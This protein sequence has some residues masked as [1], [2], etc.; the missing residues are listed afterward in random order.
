[1]S[2]ATAVQFLI[3]IPRQPL[4]GQPIAPNEPSFPMILLSAIVW[5]PALTAIVLLFFPARTDAHKDR[6]RSGAL[7]ATG[8]VLGLAL[9]LWSSFRSQFQTYA[10]EENRDWIKTIGASYHLGVDGVSMALVLL[11]AILFFV[12]V[13]ASWGVRDRSKEYFILL[14]LVETGVNGV[15]ASLDFLLFF[16]F[17]EM[18]LIPMFFLIGLWGGPR[19][20]YAAWKYVAF[21]LTGSAGLLLAI[22]IMYFQAPARTFDMATLHNAKLPSA[23]GTLLFWLFFLVFASKLGAVPLHTWLPDAQVEASTPIAVIMAGVLL[24]MGG[25]GLYRVNVG[26]FFPVP[27]P[28]TRVVLA[29]ALATIFWGALVALVQDDMKRMVA[30]S[31]LTQMGFVILAVAAATS[32]ALDGGVLLM[33]AHGLSVALLFLLVGAVAERAGSRSIAALGGLAARMPRATVLFTITAFAA[34][35]VPGLAGFIA[36]LL[37]FMGAYPVQRWGASLA[38]FGSLFVAAF[39]LWMI[40]RVFF[41]TPGEAH[42]RVRDVGTLELSYG[43]LLLTL[44]LILGLL[45]GLLVDGINSGVLTLLLRGS[46]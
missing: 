7:A 24:K 30:Y 21:G 44:L 16:L 42:V 1:M 22:L 9:A 14:L 29:V 34:V 33:V 27:Q 40:Q 31:S 26:Q 37:I 12:A 20:M 41:G 11:T 10:F 43:S 19:R 3:G 6:I 38:V 35:G 32:T 5:V 8:V 18:E 15:F 2:P 46:P 25:Y 13:I 28:V 36:Q 23:V 4:P 45:P 17:W 39:L